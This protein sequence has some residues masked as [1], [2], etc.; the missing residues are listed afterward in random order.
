[1]HDFI[2]F[3]SE[4]YD[5]DTRFL[6]HG[7]EFV[8]TTYILDK[9]ITKGSR[10]L[11]V[12]AGTGAYTVYYARKGCSVVAIDA[13]SKN[14]DILREKIRKQPD[15][16]IKAYVSDIRSPSIPLGTDY[17]LILFMGPVYHLPLPETERCLEFC[18][19]LLKKD[20]ILA[21]SYVNHHEGHQGS[22]Y[23]DVFIPYRPMEIEKLLNNRISPIFHGPTDGEVFGEL[24][25]FTEGLREEISK[26]HDWLYHNPSVFKDSSWPQTSIHG[27]YVGRKQAVSKPISKQ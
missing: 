25:S 7:T 16:D 21:V 18:L 27:L 11:D 14:I 1:M 24:N 26:L 20:G 19:S 2:K 12:G 15:L 8:S 22:K 4:E 9:L 10:I 13:V 23:Q 5:E 17:D 6:R 3:Y